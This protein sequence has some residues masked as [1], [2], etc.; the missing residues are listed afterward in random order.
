MVK[1]QYIMVLDIIDKNSLQEIWMINKFWEMWGKLEVK[2]LVNEYT[3]DIR[4]YRM[5]GRDIYFESLD[6]VP[7]CYWFNTTLVYNYFYGKKYIGKIIDQNL[8]AELK[9]LVKSIMLKEFNLKAVN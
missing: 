1:D 7:D 2:K 5:I 6:I 3:N 9:E 4:I 8:M